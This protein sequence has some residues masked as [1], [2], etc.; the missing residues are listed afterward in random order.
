MH[1][2]QTRCFAVKISWFAARFRGK[3]GCKLFRGRCG[4]SHV[5]AVSVRNGGENIANN[6]CGAIRRR[7][8]MR[9]QSL[10]QKYVGLHGGSEHI[11][12]SAALSLSS[13]SLSL[14]L[15]LGTSAMRSWVALGVASLVGFGIQRGDS[16][17]GCRRA[18]AETLIRSPQRT[19]SLLK[20]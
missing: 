10:Q 19:A 13:L 20:L 7:S 1:T 18:T 11:E 5:P 15:S 8:V 4:L 9:T 3:E 6:Q 16:M 2:S 14:S 12:Q 17:D